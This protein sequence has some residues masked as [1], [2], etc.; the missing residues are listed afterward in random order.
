LTNGP[1]N[2]L[3]WLSYHSYILNNVSI[4]SLCSCWM[5][6]F[7]ILVSEL[8]YPSVLLF[9]L[10]FVFLKNYIHLKMHVY[11]YLVKVHDWADLQ[12]ESQLLEHSNAFSVQIF[13]WILDKP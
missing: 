6:K 7:N 10:D 5:V 9:L 11:I 13:V 2:V 4:A 3:F 1:L 8:P 12:L